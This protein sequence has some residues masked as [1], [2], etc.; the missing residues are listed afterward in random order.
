MSSF[1]RLVHVRK[2]K[3]SY[4]TYRVST[5]IPSYMKIGQLAFY[6]EGGCGQAHDITIGI[7]NL[8]KSTLKTK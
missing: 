8:K 7:L 4:F 6:C 3:I 1:G 5:R 2:L